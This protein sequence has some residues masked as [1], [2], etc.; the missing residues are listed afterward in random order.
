MTQYKG[1]PQL[2]WEDCV[3]KDLRRP[4]K[5]TAVRNEEYHDQGMVKIFQHGARQNSHMS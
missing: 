4:G 3:R 2:R 1:R 5:E